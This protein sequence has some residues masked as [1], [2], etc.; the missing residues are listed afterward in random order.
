MTV[1]MEFTHIGK[2]VGF[3]LYGR[4]RPEDSPATANVTLDVKTIEG[5]GLMLEC[6]AYESEPDDLHTG[7]LGVGDNVRVRFVLV[8]NRDNVV[9][10]VQ[11]RKYIM[12]E[13]SVQKSVTRGNIDYKICGEILAIKPQPDKQ[14]AQYE[15]LVVLDCGVYL[16][17]RVRPDSIFRVGDYVR[18]RGRLDAHILEKVV[19]DI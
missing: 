15:G 14:M 16:S 13:R 8:N 11:G 1:E 5:S 3:S 9:E 18:T 10:S 6:F 17:A 19:G 12:N 4:I 2:I 7:K